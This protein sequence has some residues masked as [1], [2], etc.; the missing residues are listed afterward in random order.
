MPTIGRRPA[1]ARPRR[2]VAMSLKWRTTAQTEALPALRLTI[3]LAWS[4]RFDLSAR[5]LDRWPAPDRERRVGVARAQDSHAGATSLIRP[6]SLSWMPPL[7]AASPSLSPSLSVGRIGLDWTPAQ[8]VTGHRQV[9]PL[10]STAPARIEGT[11]RG[12]VV[13]PLR[14]PRPSDSMGFVRGAWGGIVSADRAWRGSHSKS[15]GAAPDTGRFRHVSAGSPRWA[16]S[17]SS[18]PANADFRMP[19]PTPTLLGPHAMPERLAAPSPPSP[20]AVARLSLVRPR[21]TGFAPIATRGPAL[22]PSLASAPLREQSRHKALLLHGGKRAGPAPR[23]HSALELSWPARAERAVTSQDLAVLA[24]SMTA[25]ALA[26]TMSD[27]PELLR[28]NLPGSAGASVM[29]A[30]AKAGSTDHLVEEVME[31][32]DRRLRRDRLRRGL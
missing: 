3:N 9:G 25:P 10:S 21:A 5:G 1:A 16:E 15:H 32:L 2:H 27:S 22:R 18:V 19:A 30:P 17:F 29:A 31:R 6:L 24:R 23:L 7:I 26:R 14:L 12:A 11:G 4:A 13:A 28:G 20:L 8:F